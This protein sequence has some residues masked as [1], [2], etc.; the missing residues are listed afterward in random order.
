MKKLLVL[1]MVVVLC[2]SLCACGSDSTNSIPSYPE[3][4]MK[5]TASTDI[6]DFTLSDASF[7]IFAGNTVNDSYLS[8]TDDS[9]SMYGAPVGYTFVIPTFKITN[10]DRAGS[11][12]VGGT[13]SD[14][15][16]TWEINYNGQ[17]YPVVGWDLND[18]TGGDLDLSPGAC[19]DPLTGDLIENSDTTNSLI[20]AGMSESYRILGMVN[21]EPTSLDDGF[22]LT[23]NVMNSKNE[24]EYFTYIIPAK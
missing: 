12:D 5:E 14:W 6:I 10:K 11:L 4:Q 24:Y 17:I 1:L 9:N 8:P 19:L 15:K 20:S 3:L 13:F 18:K 22:E 23:V 7:A 2:V 16:F 21:M